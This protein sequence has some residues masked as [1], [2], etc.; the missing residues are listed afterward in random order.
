MSAIPAE[1]LLAAM[2]V[3]LYVQDAASLLHFD[4]VLV[5]GG[6]RGWRVTT[7]SDLELRGRFLVVPS[8]LWPAGT[9]YRASWLHPAQ[10]ALEQPDALVAFSTR[11]W[12]L[13]A[14]V[15]L[16]GMA[17]LLVLPAL[18]LTSRDPLWMLVA[19]SI[20]YLAIIAMLVWLCVQRRA[21]G[22]T[23]RRLASLAVESLLCPPHAVNLYRRLCALRGFEGDPIAFA[24][25]TMPADARDAL[26]AGIDA[27]I[28]LFAA[29]DET[30]AG[31]VAGLH[32]ARR[33]IGEAL[34]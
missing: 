11:L 27:R 23:A 16:A 28:A 26:R 10:G 7:G 2:L 33:R 4:E 13:R 31:R 34:A 17:W 5:A 12:P 1:W 22:L 15:V 9:V 19:A 3:V 6:A 21:L 14:G 32:A 8:P 18:L 25:C 24:A 30:A 20:G 29:E